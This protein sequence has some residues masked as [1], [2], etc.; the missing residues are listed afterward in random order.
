MY[1]R[2]IHKQKR[3]KSEA[4][5]VTFFYP[6]DIRETQEEQEQGRR[7]RVSGESERERERE[8]EREQRE[9]AKTQSKIIIMAASASALKTFRSKLLPIEKY[10]FLRHLQSA[11]PLTLYRVL[12]ANA[13]ECLP[14]VYTPTVG[15][16]CEKYHV[17]PATKTSFGLFINKGDVG[18]VGAG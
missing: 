4:V 10:S 7:E 16:A 12:A 18:K 3:R 17:L 5:V 14:F 15:E 8:R 11:E 13:M 6:L 2:V 1:V 9:R